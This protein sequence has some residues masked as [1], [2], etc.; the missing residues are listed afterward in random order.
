MKVDMVAYAV[1]LSKKKI[2]NHAAT[3]LGAPNEILSFLFKIFNF[4]PLNFLLLLYHTFFEVAGILE[5]LLDDDI[6]GIVVVLDGHVSQTFYE[7]A[8]MIRLVLG[9]LLQSFDLYLDRVAGLTSIYI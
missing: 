3:E 5:K 6:D 8:N 7:F 1:I 2:K 9:H 4:L